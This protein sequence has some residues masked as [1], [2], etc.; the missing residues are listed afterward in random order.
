ML[1]VGGDGQLVGFRDPSVLPQALGGYV[2]LS[3]RY[4]FVFKL[5]QSRL[6]QAIQATV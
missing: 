4:G 1:G 5:L 6:R 2:V 3:G